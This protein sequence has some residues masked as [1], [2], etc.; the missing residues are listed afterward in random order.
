MNGDISDSAK[1]G[2]GVL[3]LCF[4]IGIVF[5][6]FTMTRGIATSGA[7]QLSGSMTQMND[8]AYATYDNETVF[9]T[10]VINAITTYSSDKFIVVVDNRNADT[11]NNT[12]ITIS[13]S[14]TL[15]NSVLADTTKMNN[16]VK[17][18]GTMSY[19]S[20]Y[21]YRVS[22]NITYD[23][24]G[25]LVSTLSTDGSTKF[26]NSAPTKVLGQPQSYVNQSQRYDARLIKDTTNKIIGIYFL[27]RK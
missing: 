4:V 12:E 22:D 17:S 15:N 11:S 2:I 23:N 1:L 18:T 10:S 8:A 5:N 21:G 25:Y 9:G 3:L 16:A 19:V 14:F 27:L 13:S 26:T 7:N 6:L 20:Y 24:A